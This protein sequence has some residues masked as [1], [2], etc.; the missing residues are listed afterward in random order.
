MTNKLPNC[1][2]CGVAP[3]KLH[4]VGCDVERC[5]TCGGQALSCG[6]EENALPR[7]PWSGKWLGVEECQ[8]FGWYARLISGQGWVSC[9]ASD[10][11][12]HADLNRLAV[13]AVWSQKAKRFIK[14]DDL[15]L[16]KASTLN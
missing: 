11:D 9:K 16:D 15:P 6:C 7:L 8:E 5:A 13:E 10:K 4:Q 2:D 14:V 3:G 1:P 12:A